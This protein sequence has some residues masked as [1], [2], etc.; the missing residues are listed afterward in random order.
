M[1]F[2]IKL[3]IFG[4]IVAGGLWFYGSTLP[5]E[6]KASS[7]ITLV[8]TPEQVYAAARDIAQTP[9]WWR[10]VNAVRPLKGK[11]RESWE[12]EM[13][14]AGP[15]Q[16]EITSF[17]E[18]QRLV[19]TILNDDQQ[20]WGGRWTYAIVRTASGT[21]VTI[22]ETGW[23]EPPLYRVVMKVRGGP[24]R[25]LDSYLRSLGAKFGEIVTPRHDVAG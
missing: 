8:A 3:V 14:G 18:N 7:S 4:G 15:V 17:V 21:E 20:D 24:H 6:H 11:R 12:Q 25:T 5:R 2:L 23:I 19:T 16:I 10:D 9:T 22:T 13:K 1:R